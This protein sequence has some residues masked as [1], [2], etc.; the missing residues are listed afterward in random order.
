MDITSLTFA[1]NK[2][3]D[4]YVLADSLRKEHID[5]NGYI[6]TIKDSGFDHMMSQYIPNLKSQLKLELQPAVM[7]A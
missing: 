6:G 4:S 2:Q 3:D 7:N 1:A 5:I